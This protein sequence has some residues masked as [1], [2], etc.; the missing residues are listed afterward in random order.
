MRVVA[1]GVSLVVVPLVALPSVDAA[2]TAPSSA[3]PVP[4][5]LLSPSVAAIGDT[6]IV[7]GT[8]FS[9]Q[10][11]FSVTVCGGGGSGTSTTCAFGDGVQTASE[12]DGS[13]STP[14]VVAAPPVACPCSV[15]I[16]SL[17]QVAEP[18]LAPLTIT[19]MPTDIAPA[20]TT[21]PAPSLSV[22]QTEIRVDDAWFAFIGGPSQ[23]MLLLEVSNNGGQAVVP[24]AIEVR[25]GPPGNVTQFVAGPPPPAIGP[26]ETVTITIPVSFP[27]LSTGEQLVQG[28]I[29][30]SFGDT[31][32][33][34]STTIRWW[35]AWV[36]PIAIVFELFLIALWFFLRRLQSK[37]VAD[38]S[39]VA[40][41]NAPPV[42]GY[43][44]HS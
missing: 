41:G 3:A 16:A 5:V 28:R 14:I 1:A 6:V 13:L 32:F 37:P 27:S 8:G 24:S 36:V 10:Q 9:P 4:T 7:S 23:R 17:D 35:S 26:G 15:R 25:S 20:P 31:S 18:V 19:D 22:E 30:T 42:Q 21:V 39:A 11:L 2:A 44:D 40:D 34:A 33:E 29:I 12:S 43:S 38:S